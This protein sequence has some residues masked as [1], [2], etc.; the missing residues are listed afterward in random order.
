MKSL[1]EEYEED[2]RRY[3][4]LSE[5][6]KAEFGGKARVWETD[7]GVEVV[8]KDYK[9]T[10]VAPRMYPEKGRV[11]H[12]FVKIAPIVD[13]PVEEWLI[14]YLAGRAMEWGWKLRDTPG[15]S[16]EKLKR[17]IAEVKLLKWLVKEASPDAL[18]IALALSRIEVGVYPV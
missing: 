10:V 18:L 7:D 16:F 5:L 8:T 13:N 6:L 14:T 4:D 17:Y 1:E 2:M 3:R 15:Y 12:A 9:V 11:E